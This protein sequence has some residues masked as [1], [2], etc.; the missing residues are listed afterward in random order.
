MNFLKNRFFLRTT[1]KSIILLKTQITGK[2][3]FVAWFTSI[4]FGNFL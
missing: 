4:I 3:I 1:S 2:I